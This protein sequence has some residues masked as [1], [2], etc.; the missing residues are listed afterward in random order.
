MLANVQY[1][2]NKSQCHPLASS[3]NDLLSPR[4]DLLAHL[5]EAVLCVALGEGRDGFDGLVDVVL[6][7]GACLLEPG[8]SEHDFASL[9]QNISKAIP[10]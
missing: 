1:S 9:K 10:D 4:Q 8:A 5:N 7:Q 2:Y 3:R 6:C